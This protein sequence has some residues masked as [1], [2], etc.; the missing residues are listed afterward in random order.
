LERDNI[1][2]L[3]YSAGFEPICVYCGVDHPFTSSEQYPQHEAYSHLA[4]VKKYHT[5]FLWCE[6]L[7][8]VL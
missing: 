3:D 6:L 7:S 1:E 5:L 2:K 8:V 4:P